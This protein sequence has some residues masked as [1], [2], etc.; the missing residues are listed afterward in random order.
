MLADGED[1]AH[2]ASSVQLSSLLVSKE[3]EVLN[4]VVSS[5]CGCPRARGHHPH[6]ILHFGFQ[7]AQRL[8]CQLVTVPRVTR[9]AVEEHREWFARITRAN[10]RSEDCVHCRSKLDC[11]GT[12][13]FLVDLPD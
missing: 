7:P 8:D 10:V 12:V 1:Q 9:P 6:P 11:L 13:F 2:I 5:V 4:E 3:A